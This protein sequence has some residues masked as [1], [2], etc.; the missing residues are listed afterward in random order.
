MQNLFMKIFANCSRL[1]NAVAM[2]YLLCLIVSS[3]FLCVCFCL[4]QFDICP[5]GRRLMI[6]VFSKIVIYGRW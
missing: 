6:N 1:L 3:V 2:P 4:C 5:K